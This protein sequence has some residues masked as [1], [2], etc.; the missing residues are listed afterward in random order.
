MYA[1][2]ENSTVRSNVPVRV[3]VSILLKEEIGPWQGKEDR[4]F[5]LRVI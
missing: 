3:E 4:L 5:D 2:V 1:T